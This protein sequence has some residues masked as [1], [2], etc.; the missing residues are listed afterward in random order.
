MS[1][2]GGTRWACYAVKAVAAGDEI[3]VEALCLSAVRER[4]A[5]LR[6]IDA[7]DTHV[8]RFGDQRGVTRVR[9]GKEIFLNAGLT[10]G[11]HALAGVAKGIHKQAAAY[12]PHQQHAIVRFALPFQT[13]AQPVA[14]QDLDGRRLQH[15]RADAR[16]H[17]RAVVLFHHNGANVMLVQDFRQQ[18]ARRAGA[19]NCN[20]S[21]HDLWGASDQTMNPGDEANAQATTDITIQE[22][23]RGGLM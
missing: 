18:H 22:V 21:A 2:S 3:A 14:P 17:M 5:G 11:R 12:R 1:G 16:E 9:R 8:L 7:G 19:D 4:E 13:C 23:F 20:F 6:A 10:V 15:A